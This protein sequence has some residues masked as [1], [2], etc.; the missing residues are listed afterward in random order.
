MDDKIVISW[1]FAGVT[2]SMMLSG[3]MAFLQG[4]CYVA[5]QFIGAII[6]AAHTKAM[7]PESV[8]DPGCF[9][10]VGITHAKLFGMEFMA[11]LL[12]IVTVY[13]VAVAQKGR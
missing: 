4:L 7:K 13:G 8:I 5:M 11:T 3:H 9:G 1:W 6:G 12:L 10:P 2:W